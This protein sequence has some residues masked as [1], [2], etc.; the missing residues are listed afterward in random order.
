[1]IFQAFARQCM[2][3]VEDHLEP[4]KFRTS[5]SSPADG[6]AIQGYIHP[7][8]LIR[9]SN[10]TLSRVESIIVPINS[11]LNVSVW[12][13]NT[14]LISV[15]VMGAFDPTLDILFP[16]RNNAKYAIPLQILVSRW[17]VLFPRTCTT[18]GG[19]DL[20]GQDITCSQ[21]HD[22][23]MTWA[24]KIGG[25]KRLQRGASQNPRVLRYYTGVIRISEW[26]SES[27]IHPTADIVQVTW[28]IVVHYSTDDSI[29]KTAK[30]M[31]YYRARPAGEHACI[32]HIS[33][34]DS[35][36]YAD[37]ARRR[38]AVLVFYRFIFFVMINH[39]VGIHYRFS[40]R[41]QYIGLLYFVI[42]KQAEVE[43]P[44]LQSLN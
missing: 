22:V 13:E 21:Q 27:G 37:I 11:L 44:Q 34:G 3:Y 36:V 2:P 8:Y 6:K 18:E 5:W 43:K 42:V 41:G 7:K 33:A 20:E 32:Y 30:Q 40:I 10:S 12:H 29:S 15:S 9:P 25:S 23:G 16:S 17:Y 39:L 35:R 31:Y 14:S 4:W 26:E 1:M 38:Y 24:W 19:T 28:N